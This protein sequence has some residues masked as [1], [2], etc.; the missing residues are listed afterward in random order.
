MAAGLT[1]RNR[2]LARAFHLR[3]PRGRIRPAPFRCDA[4]RGA[5]TGEWLD[6]RCADGGG[7]FTSFV[8]ELVVYPAICELWRWHLEMKRARA[9]Q[10][11]AAV[12]ALP[13]PE[14]APSPH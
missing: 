3:F 2:P 8:L 13:S 1:T 9:E 12:A 11:P 14:P 6:A 10:E 5:S 4:S 7:I